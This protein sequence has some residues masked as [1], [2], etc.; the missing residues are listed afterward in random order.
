MK[1]KMERIQGYFRLKKEHEEER[2]K[3][4]TEMRKRLYASKG[5]PFEINRALL[6]SEVLHVRNKQRE[7]D[8]IL[9]LQEAEERMQYA[10]QVLE[11][12]KSAKEEELS[13]TERR[14]Q[15]KKEIQKEY[16]IYKQNKEKS[17]EKENNEKHKEMI[18]YFKMIEDLEHVETLRKEKVK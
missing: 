1:L 13:N 18:E 12:C 11:T 17:K 3:F 14:R 7:F 10:R 9:K 16:E 5:Y 15:K 4:V 6:L 8:R 2:N